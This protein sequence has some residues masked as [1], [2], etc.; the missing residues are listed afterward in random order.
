MFQNSKCAVKYD[1]K[2]TEYI[3]ITCSW[4]PAGPRHLCFIQNVGIKGYKSQ[5]GLKKNEL[6]CLVKW[7][8]LVTLPES[9]T[10]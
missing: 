2:I 3:F 6:T 1:G 8:L 4:L 7:A 5:N 10:F 9:V